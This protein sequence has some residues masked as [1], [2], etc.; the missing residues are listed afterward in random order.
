MSNEARRLAALVDD[1]GP[2]ERSNSAFRK[3]FVSR[4]KALFDS[5]GAPL[6]G[7]S[8]APFSE[9]LRVM[10]SFPSYSLGNQSVISLQSPGAQSIANAEGWAALG[11]RVDEHRQLGLARDPC[12]DHLRGCRGP[13]QILG[14]DRHERDDVRRP[15]TRVGALVRAQVDALECN[16]DPREQRVAELALRADDREDRPVV[17]RVRVHVQQSRVT[18]QRSADRVDGESIAALAEVRNGLERQHS[19]TLGLP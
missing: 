12:P 9:L 19:R 14:H 16:T 15:D 3:D 8:D 13:A 4:T 5:F 11:R 1:T 7:T 6:A 2:L 18:R 17:V 10:A